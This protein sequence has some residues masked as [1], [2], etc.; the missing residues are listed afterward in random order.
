MPQS[1]AKLPTVPSNHDF[2]SLLKHNHPKL[3]LRSA[4]SNAIKVLPV[5]V[6]QVLN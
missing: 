1:E 5:T 4:S 3:D 2:S 6:E